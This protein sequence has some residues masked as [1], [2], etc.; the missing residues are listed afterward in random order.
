MTDKRNKDNYNTWAREYRKKNP[1][2]HKGQ[3]L[4]RYWPGLTGPEAYVEYMKIFDVQGGRCAICGIP[5]EELSR[6]LAVD[7]C[8]KTQKVR[9]LLCSPCNG[10]VVVTVEHYL[11][12][13]AIT[14]AYLEKHK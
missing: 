14:Q 2:K 4:K 13:I 5:N 10:Q 8:H 9:G 3:N 6:E 7:H 1:E 12:R 11:D